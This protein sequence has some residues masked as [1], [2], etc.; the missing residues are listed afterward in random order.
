[1]WAVRIETERLLLRRLSEPDADAF[2]EL[3][4][5]PQ[6]LRFIAVK[7][8][9]TRD[10]ALER[11]RDDVRAWDELGQRIV[12]IEERATGRFAGRVLL[13]DWPQFGETEIGWTLMADARGRGYATEA[14]R[15]LIE[16]GFANLD[17]PY[18]V[19]MVNRDNEPSRRVAERLG[20]S[21]LREEELDGEPHLVYALR[22]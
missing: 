17:V 22:R 6:V 19:S 10:D 12:A 20:M 14:A 4:N 1:M 8:P 21:V 16:W 3:F 15:A 2:A 13:Y 9:Y 11:I 7:Q 5:D 18:L